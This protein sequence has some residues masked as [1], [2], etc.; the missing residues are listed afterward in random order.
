MFKLKSLFAGFMSLVFL[1][2]WPSLAYGQTISAEEEFD[3]DYSIVKEGDKVP[4]DGFLFDKDGIINVIV[5]KNLEIQKLTIN[6][7]SEIAKLKIEI[8]SIN[9]QH[10]LELQ[11]N[12]DLTDSL[13][14]L[15]D[16]RIKLLEDSK[17]WDDVKLFGAVLI[18]IVLSVTIFYAA[19]QITNIKTQ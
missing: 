15:R 6:K 11:I 4:Y 18:G 2:T 16:D 13:V 3:G 19:V 14:K 8:D 1:A 17:R 7:D 9:K 12:K 10:K 5:N